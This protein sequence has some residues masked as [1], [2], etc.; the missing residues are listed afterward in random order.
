MNSEVQKKSSKFS[1]T[2]DLFCSCQIRDSMKV[3]NW[4]T[5]VIQCHEIMIQKFLKHFFNIFLENG[6]KNDRYKTSIVKNLK[7]EYTIDID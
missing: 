2:A 7:C 5:A 3:N 4:G 6:F 1:N